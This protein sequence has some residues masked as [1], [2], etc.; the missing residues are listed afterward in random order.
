LPQERLKIKDI[1]RK[2][3]DTLLENRELAE[4]YR[5][6]VQQFGEGELNTII[7]DMVVKA[8]DDEALKEE[9]FS[10]NESLFSL[11]C[12][13]WIQFLLSDIAGV[14]KDKL[15]TMVREM[16]VDL[17]ESKIYH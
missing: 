17:L 15:Q 3:V 16:F 7:M 11:F 6:A 2:V 9:A 4:L 1:S 12:G 13:I 5:R 14:H 10:N 8:I